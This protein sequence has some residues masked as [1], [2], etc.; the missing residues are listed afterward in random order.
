MSS[1]DLTVTNRGDTLD[2]LKLFVPAVLDAGG[3]DAPVLDV[4]IAGALHQPGERAK[5]SSTL[6]AEIHS[7]RLP[8]SLACEAAHPTLCRDLELAQ[9]PFYYASGRD[10][11][12]IWVAE[13]H[14]PRHRDRGAR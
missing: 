5:H 3:H 1:R 2:L 11:P 14:G 13:V 12:Q 9:R 8:V 4:M 6:E 7:Q 10:S